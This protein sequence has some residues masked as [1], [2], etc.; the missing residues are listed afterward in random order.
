MGKHITYGYCRC[1][2]NEELQNIDRQIRDLKNLGVDEKY[3]YTE[4]ESGTKRDRIEFNRL[5]DIIKEGDT[6]VATEVSRISRST[7]HL[8]EIIE[9]VKQKKVR[10]ILGGFIVDCREGHIDA[11][12]EGMLKMM[13]VFSEMERNIIS[14]RVKSG[15]Q[16]AREKG[17]K[18]GRPT[19]NI[20]DIPQKF[21][22]HYELYKKGKINK[23][24]LSRL[25]ELSR[26]TVN[27]YLKLMD[28]KS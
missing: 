19:T 23:S 2:T 21:K 13:A 12:T 14:E 26:P 22:Q 18:I 4:Y 11:M 28:T 16:N 1:S 27:K 5:M 24:D 20:E 25:T 7:M 3:I 9:E 17:S 8:C 6:I 15:M 10:L